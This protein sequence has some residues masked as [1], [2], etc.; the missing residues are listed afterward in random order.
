M[1]AVSTKS[2]VGS[3]DHTLQRLAHLH[4]HLEARAGADQPPGWIRSADLFAPGSPHL[5]PI[6]DAVGAA[7]GSD[8]RQ[9][10]VSF[11]LNAYAWLVAAVGLGCIVV[12]AR[13]PDLAFENVA[14]RFNEDGRALGIAF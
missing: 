13:L 7:T 6:L 10:A 14:V 3:L 4:P 1:A 12:D 11:F 9:I 2:D 8:D 5:T